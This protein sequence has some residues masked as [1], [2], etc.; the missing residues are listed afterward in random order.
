MAYHT[1]ITCIECGKNKN[2]I[3]SSAGE[4]P[5]QCR[6]CQ[7]KEA[8]RQRKEYFAELDKLPP[9]E[10]VRKIEQWIYEYRPTYVPPP[11]F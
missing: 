5:T 1:T 10:R 2:I 4:Y 9:E 8:Y 11:R 3:V 6:E 7:D